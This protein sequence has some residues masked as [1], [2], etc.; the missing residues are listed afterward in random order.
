MVSKQPKGFN[1]NDKLLIVDDVMKALVRM[2]KISLEINLRPYLSEL[3]A[4]LG[5]HLQRIWEAWC[6]NAMERHIFL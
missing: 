5:K 1:E 2:A 4:P 3:P 6:L